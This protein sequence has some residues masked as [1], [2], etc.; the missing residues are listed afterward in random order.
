MDRSAAFA[1]VVPLLGPRVVVRYDRRGY[2]R[3]SLDGAPGLDIAGHAADLLAVV[4]EHAGGRAVVIGHSIGGVVALRAAGDRPEAVAAVGAYEA[5]MAWAPWW[6]RH[7]AGGGATAAG[8]AGGPGAAAEAFLRRMLGDERWD[9]LG[10]GVQAQRRAEGVALVAE[11]RAIRAA[12]APYDLD[13]VRCPVLAA[14]GT[15]SAAHHQRAADELARLVDPGSRPT[16]IAGA[17]HGAHLSHPAEFAEWVLAVVA[18]GSA[19]T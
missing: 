3:S 4:D 16:V 18:T 2:G 12:T 6:P 15:T 10:E 17:G 7:S 5:P 19:R 8:D 9:A 1:R 13:R 11:L 14:R